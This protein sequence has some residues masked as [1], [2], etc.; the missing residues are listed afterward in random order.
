M[1]RQNYSV[2]K[3]FISQPKKLPLVCE[4]LRRDGNLLLDALEVDP[5][6]Y[7]LSHFLPHFV[8]YFKKQPENVQLEVFNEHFVDGI[9]DFY[10]RF[11]QCFKKRFTMNWEQFIDLMENIDGYCEQLRNKNKPI[12]QSD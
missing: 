11:C 7:N 10:D 5:P 2:L 1:I 12:S 8:E 4:I 6:I 9:K 3:Y